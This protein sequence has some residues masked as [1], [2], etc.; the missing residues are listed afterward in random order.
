MHSQQHGHPSEL[1]CQPTRC[2]EV[3]T[4]SKI[5]PHLCRAPKVCAIP[6][7]VQTK[8]LLHLARYFAPSSANPPWPYRCRR[9]LSPCSRARHQLQLG[10]RYS[11]SRTR[12]TLRK[13]ETVFRCLR[14]FQHSETQVCRERNARHSE[15]LR[16]GSAASIV[17]TLMLDR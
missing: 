1:V 13:L 11:S 8:A 10:T 2:I 12:L 9:P 5:S 6:A 3:A 16:P 7:V 14:H 4:A 15:Q 17:A